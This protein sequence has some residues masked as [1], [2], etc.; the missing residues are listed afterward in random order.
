MVESKFDPCQRV[1]F[2]KWLLPGIGLLVLVV[3]VLALINQYHSGPPEGTVVIKAGE[4]VLGS[5]T[6]AD[7]RKLPAVEKKI[8]VQTNCSLKSASSSRH[9]YT[10]TSL[11]GVLDRVDPG[12][13]QKYQKVITRGVDYY[14]QVLDMSEVLQPD[15]VYIVYADNGRLLKTKD[16][17]E[18]SLQLVISLDKTGQRYTNWLVSLELQ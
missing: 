8:V 7:L 1:K 5:F 11:Q 15:N 13:T 4:T 10:G 12:L 14:S 3:V 6:V 16:G 18:G 2:K 9:D 17:R